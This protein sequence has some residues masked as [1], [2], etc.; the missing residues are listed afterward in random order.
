MKTDS[1]IKLT[2]RLKKNI[3]K[4]KRKLKKILKQY[5]KFIKPTFNYY[6]K[7][8]ISHTNIIIPRNKNLY[9]LNKFIN[10]QLFIRF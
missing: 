5:N 4:R 1:N 3:T 7:P 10:Q 6:I 2:K 8:T 9:L